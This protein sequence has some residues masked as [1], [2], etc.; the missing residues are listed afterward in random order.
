VRGLAL[1]AALAL[2]AAAPA[3][4]VYRWVDAEGK[5]H[6]ADSP[7]PD[8]SA[9]KLAIR[10]AP[11]DPSSVATDEELLATRARQSAEESA[12]EAAVAK[13]TR[14]DAA[15]KAEACEA[16]R[17]RHAGI[18][19]SRKFA[20]KDQ[21]GNETWVSGADALAVKEQAAAAVRAACGG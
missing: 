12:V 17:T 14:E 7:P 13:K 8:V 5:I 2:S 1:L 4:D 16:A 21:A 6:F 20:T 9:E 11:T 19:H 3:T 10:S 15:A 18:E